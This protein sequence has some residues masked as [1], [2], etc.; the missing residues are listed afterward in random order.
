[1]FFYLIAGPLIVFLYFYSKTALTILLGLIVISTFSTI[2]RKAQPKVRERIIFVK[3]MISL[4]FSGDMLSAIGYYWKPANI[5][6]WKSSS[7]MW[8]P[9]KPPGNIL[10]LSSPWSLTTCSLSASSLSMISWK[11]F[12]DSN[13][14]DAS[15]EYVFESL[16]WSISTHGSTRS[17]RIRRP[18]QEC[19]RREFLL[20][21]VQE[22]FKKL[23]C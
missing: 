6:M 14:L 8:K 19:W 15:Q 13:V 16:W 5:F 12:Q 11:V 9:W 4:S 22:E 7:K 21:Y 23:L 20:S 3:I 1:M 18:W 2:N 10:Q 17:A